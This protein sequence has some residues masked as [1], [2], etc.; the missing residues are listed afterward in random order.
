[1]ELGLLLLIF[2]LAIASIPAFIAS[3]KGRDFL[4]WFIYSFFLFPFAFI[5][6]IVIDPNEKA[7]GMK[8][9][10][11]CAS[12]ISKD[13]TIC[14]LCQSELKIKSTAKI[15]NPTLNIKAKSTDYFSDERDLKSS[16]YQLFLTRRFEIEKNNTLEKYIIGN[17]VFD[18]L[19]EALSDAD[20]K[21]SKFIS[22]Q[23]K[24][25]ESNALANRE[26]LEQQAI[27]KEQYEIARKKKNI[28]DAKLASLIK[29]ISIYVSLI[30][31]IIS[32]TWGYYAFNE[33]KER[34]AALE[35][36]LKLEMIENSRRLAEAEAA[37]I[38]SNEEYERQRKEIKTMFSEGNFFGLKIGENNLDKLPGSVSFHPSANNFG[39]YF[40]ECK[41]DECSNFFPKYSHDEIIDSIRLTYCVSHDNKKKDAKFYKL[42]IVEFSGFKR[43]DEPT[44]IKF[45]LIKEGVLPVPPKDVSQ[46]L[47]DNWRS[48]VLRWDKSGEMKNDG[49]QVADIC[50][51]RVSGILLH[52]MR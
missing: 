49:K 50:G 5:H 13:A 21:Y 9:C 27:K 51:N 12:T 41:K 39:E 3:H 22:I 47:K 20:L 6:A 52:Y 37:R 29:K 17:N 24:A 26:S 32:S 40:I 44:K 46:T 8:K 36:K 15:F 35:A 34:E 7:K 45:E 4:L 30:I 23:K 10:P 25:E 48:L 28:D 1:M 38:K 19:D 33:N 42:R 43:S 2:I 11:Q 14:P 18:S 16:K 31:V